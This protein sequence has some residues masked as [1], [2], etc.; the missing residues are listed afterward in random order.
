MFLARDLG[1]MALTIGWAA[2][3][4]VR[5]ATSSICWRRVVA[6]F[7]SASR[8]AWTY[9]R[10]VKATSAWP[11][12]LAQGL[13]ADLGVP[14]RRDVAVAHVVQVDQREIRSWR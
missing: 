14:S 12:P 2:V 7:R 3:F 6:T 9:C 10:L 5:R 11:D 8:S 4:S 1:L 13:P